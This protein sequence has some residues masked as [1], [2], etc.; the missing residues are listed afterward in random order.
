M[1][2]GTTLE[3]CAPLR[4]PSLVVVCRRRVPGKGEQVEICFGPVQDLGRPLLI[5]K[6]RMPLTRTTAGDSTSSTARLETIDA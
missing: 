3:G 4:G 5:G 6:R 2:T 1:L